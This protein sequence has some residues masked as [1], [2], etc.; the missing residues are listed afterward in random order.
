MVQLEIQ[1]QGKWTPILR[2]DSTHGFSHVDRFNLAGKQR[3]EMLSLTFAE[4]LTYADAGINKNWE[5]YKE[6]FMRGLFP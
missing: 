1:H 2:Y 6:R 4:T 5:E 3:K